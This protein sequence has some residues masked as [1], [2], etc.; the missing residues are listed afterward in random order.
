MLS[1]QACRSTV[2]WLPTAPSHTHCQNT[3]TLRCNATICATSFAA[4]IDTRAR[5][6]RQLVQT[7]LHL[8]DETYGTPTAAYN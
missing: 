5:N 3:R 4:T 2:S 7:L 1:M 6:A 8:N